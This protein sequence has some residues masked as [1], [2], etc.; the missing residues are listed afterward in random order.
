V[1]A[2]SAAATAPGLALALALVLGLSGCGGASGS[3]PAR[4]WPPG[5]SARFSP[6][7]DVTL[8]PPFDLAAAAGDA[9]ARS[10]TLAFVD[11]AAPRCEPRWGPATPIAAPAVVTPAARLRAAGT[12]L[13]VS[14]GGSQG[15]ELARTC[16][17][18]NAL[19]TAYARVLERYHAVAADFDLER[20]AL[21]D[22]PAMAR[23]ARA[24]ALLQARF[25]RRLAVSL[26]L[27]VSAHGLSAEGLGA[28][29]AMLAAGV[30]LSSVNLLAMDYSPAGARAGMASTG[31]SAA[32]A[33]HR[34]LSALG[35]ELSSW[36]ALGLTAMVGVNDVSG[37]VLTLSDARA[38]ARFASQRG[39][40]L[41]SIWSL[42]RDEPCA[43]SPTAAQATCSGVAEPPYAFS[44][45]FGARP[46]PGLRPREAVDR[47]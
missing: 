18:V 27:P 40:R 2:R 20:A 45:A 42:A 37:E 4:V 30:H 24:I 46:R 22:L 7:V 19:Q 41:T 43:G 29:R 3:A 31:I 13:R 28:V 17:N 38:L 21:A 39:L 23:R 5:G 12:A 8:S 34:Q 36:G 16:T 35:G 15:E 6:Y 26:S 11:A 33:V 10:L 32:E 9:G 47:S 1:S 14:F 25:G 44:R